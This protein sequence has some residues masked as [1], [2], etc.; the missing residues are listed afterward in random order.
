MSNGV[1]VPL[2]T[3]LRSRPAAQTLRMATRLMSDLGV[4]QVFDATAL[5]HLALPVFMSVRP[6]G[7][8]T[9]VH[10]GKGLS[11]ADA[12]TGAVME[13]LEFAVSEVASAT[14]EVQRIS[15][16]RLEEQ[17]PAGLRIVDFAP[18]LGVR[19]DPRAR[20]PAVEC[21][22]LGTRRKAML[23]AELV[24]WPS[25]AQRSPLRFGS[26]TN[27]LASGNTLE[28]A[29]LHAL[30][31][32]LERDTLALHMARNESAA[33]VL[34]TLPHPFA[35]L[36]PAWRRR[37]VT[38]YVRH[39]PNSL[40]LPCFQAAL[41]EPAQRDDAPLLAR[42]SGLHFDRHIA[43]SRAI[44][45]AAQSRLAVILSR[46]PGL[47]GAK[48]MAARL[49]A[50]TDLQAT[51]QQLN[52]MSRRNRYV[53]FDAI[54]HSEPISIRQALGALLNRL[55]AAGFGPVFRRRLFM[56]GG[57]AM[58]AG[59]H[60]VRVVVPGSETPVDAHPRIGPRIVARL[61]GA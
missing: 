44:C 5:D 41:H 56:Q 47:P 12:H 17:W 31:E 16:A 20:L 4:T 9:R 7:T 30:L 34:S 57:T 27:G 26:S 22:I 52:R 29:T 33:L 53:R 2:G 50:S 8:T 49:D 11:A 15:L 60:V 39:L 43:L 10:S 37:G 35:G 14:C 36:A 58:T 19:L 46:R 18:R 51:E 40:G 21:E 1:N 59:L 61:Q 13:A 38:L 42:G 32:V 55:P 28:E 45:E 54:A 3:S 48:E 25:R 23:P 6:A 24:L